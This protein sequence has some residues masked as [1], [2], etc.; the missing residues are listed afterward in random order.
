MVSRA[1]KELFSY[2]SQNKVSNP[3]LG[4]ILL[5]LLPSIL[6]SLPSGLNSPNGGL[7]LLSEVAAAASS[8][9]LDHGTDSS[10]FEI[11]I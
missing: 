1:L 7:L 2:R 3:I 9:I 8:L 6:K 4:T 5:L 11:L 10:G